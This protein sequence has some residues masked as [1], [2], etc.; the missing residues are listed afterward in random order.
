MHY[1]KTIA[2]VGDAA[3]TLQKL[4]N[5]LREHKSTSSAAPSPW[6]REC[7]QQRR[8]WEEFK[9]QRYTTPT[10]YDKV[11]GR[12]LLTQPMAIKV[13]TDWARAN[14]VV[15]FFD[16]GDVQANGFQ[17]VE[18][19]EQGRTFTDT[20]GSY[21]GFAAS[22]LL[23]TGVADN[24]LYAIALSGDGSFTMNPQIL[25]DAVEHE[26]RG[27]LVI[28]DNRRMGA[29]TGL[30]M[31]QY[32]QDYKT[33]DSVATNYVALAQSVEGVKGLFGGYDTKELLEALQQAHSHQGLSV[34]H[35]PVYYG[36]NELGGLGTF[37]S[38]NVGNCSDQ[39]QKEH[40]QIGL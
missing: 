34:I 39:V 40:H 27:C 10:L 24:P 38:W 8:A 13:A 29:I 35:L 28:F 37:G 22:A 20:G 17:V 32:E 9:Q 25:F 16:A 30:Q 21:M 19:E 33:S 15:S 5:A 14:D 11:W 31:A 36:E 3:L 4:N 12:E 2:L 18:D 1:G 26:V 6:M 7:T 23:A